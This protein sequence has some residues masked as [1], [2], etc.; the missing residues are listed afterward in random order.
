MSETATKKNVC[1]KKNEGKKKQKTGDIFY[2]G[3]G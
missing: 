1:S 2:D 3:I